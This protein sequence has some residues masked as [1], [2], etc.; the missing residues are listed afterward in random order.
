M[1]RGVLV[2]VRRMWNKGKEEGS[3]YREFRVEKSF[4]VET[5][6]AV[7]GAAAGVESDE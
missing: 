6:V 5:E 2:V 3:E 4:V 7:P 1:P